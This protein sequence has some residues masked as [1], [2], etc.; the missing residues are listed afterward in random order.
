MLLLEVA[1]KEP[2]E[3]APASALHLRR[4]WVVVAVGFTMAAPA[5]WAAQVPQGVDLED[6][7]VG[8]VLDLPAVQMDRDMGEVAARPITNLERVAAGGQEVVV[9]QAILIMDILEELVC[10]APSPVLQSSMGVGVGVAPAMEACQ[11]AVA[12]VVG[13]R[14][15]AGVQMEMEFLVRTALEVE[16]E[17]AGE[18]GLVVLQEALG[19]LLSRTLQ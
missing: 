1:V 6:V 18:A 12:M 15:A 5:V 3:R 11:D 19:W 17:V 2:T 14:V 7:E 4:H 16:Q 10:Q 9:H 8:R 13:V